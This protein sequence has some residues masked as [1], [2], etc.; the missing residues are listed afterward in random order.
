M[1][2]KPQYCFA[3]ISVTKAQ[4]FMKFVVANYYLVIICIKFHSDLCINARARVVNVRN[5]DKTCARA[6][7]TRARAFMDK[8]S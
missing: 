2:K 5:R 6:F 8:S 7:T 3:N 4:I 1:I